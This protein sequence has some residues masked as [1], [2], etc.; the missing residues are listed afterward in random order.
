MHDGLA[1][2]E[3]K[4]GKAR[5][6]LRKFVRERDLAAGDQRVTMIVESSRALPVAGAGEREVLEFPAHGEAE[7]VVEGGAGAVLLV[8]RVFLF[9]AGLFRACIS[10]FFRTGF[11]GK[12]FEAAE[13]P[14]QRALA[15][16]SGVEPARPGDVGFDVGIFGEQRDDARPGGAESA[17]VLG[18]VEVVVP[19]DFDVARDA[20]GEPADGVEVEG[21]LHDGAGDAGSIEV[22]E[23][24]HVGAEAAEVVDALVESVE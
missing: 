13:Q 10:R 6:R 19:G 17:L 8:F 1:F 22:V 16:A 14:F 3:R 15:A 4:F 21:V 11:D 23:D 2:A 9:F 5:N 12:L 24:G 20:A 7:S 18:I